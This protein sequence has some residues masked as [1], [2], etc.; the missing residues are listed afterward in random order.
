MHYIFIAA[1]FDKVLTSTL[2]V[3]FESETYLC[4]STNTI[5][6]YKLSF[7]AAASPAGWPP[8][9]KIPPTR[10]QKLFA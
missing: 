6:H 8:P 2:G 3:R 9:H 7:W 10:I 1:F 4:K 5:S